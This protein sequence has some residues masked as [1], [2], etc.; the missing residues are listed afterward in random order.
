M[1]FFSFLTSDSNSLK[2]LF[3]SLQG[4]RCQLTCEAGTYYNGHKRVCE[5]CHPACATCAGTSFPC[6]TILAHCLIDITCIQLGFWKL[7]R[8]FEV[9]CS[10]CSGRWIGG[11]RMSCTQVRAWRLAPNVLRDTILRSGAVFPVATQDTTW[12][13]KPQK[14]ETSR[15]LAASQ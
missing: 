9:I 2:I 14:T 10:R 8:V 5:Q 1:F 13:R 6:S 12:Q 3:A 15:S 7:L 4:N 11:V